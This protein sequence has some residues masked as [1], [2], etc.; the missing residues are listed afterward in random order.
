MRGRFWTIAA[1]LAALAALIAVPAAVAA[2][3]SPK[4]EVAQTSAATTIKASLSPDDDP[5][6]SVRIFTPTGT[7]LTTSQAPG[8][9]IGTVQALVRALDLG[10]ADTPVTGQLTVATPG[11]IP[12]AQTAACLGT[13]GVQPVA[14][15]ALVLT[16]AGTALP[17]LGAY[18][19]PTSGAQAALGPAYLQ[20]CLPPPDVPPGTPGRASLGA[21]LY[22]ATL[23]ITGVFSSVSV[24][25]WIAFWTPYTPGAGK[26]NLNGTVASPAAVAPGAVTASARK[27]GLGAV[28]SGRV[29]QA[30]QPRGG[31]T[32]T[33]RGGAKAS[34]LKRL[35]SVKVTA[36]GSF[37]FRAKRGTFFRVTAIATSAPAA[38]L[39]TALAAALPAPCV[40]PTTNG[41]TVQ[42]KTVRKK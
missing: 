28:V 41:F 33:I 40:N 35:G 42:S 26:A 6:A 18:I 16:A 25:A 1:G 36:T 34:A 4:L 14:T 21:K 23:T 31:A 13:G 24:G 29:T 37:S 7:Q 12:A 15:W 20:I 2:Y 17:P 39:C 10:G 3:A 9:A 27:R 32:V 22:S 30:G 11:Q 5:T 19:V 8:A 38:P